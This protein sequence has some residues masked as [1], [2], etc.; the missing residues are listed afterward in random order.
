MEI[1]FQLLDC[2]YIVLDNAPIVR[3]FGKTKEGKAVCGFYR[4]FYP[5]FYVLPKQKDKVVEFLKKNFQIIKNIEEVER[6]KSINYQKEKTKMLKVTLTDPSKVPEVR[7]SLKKESFVQSVFESDILF[8]YRFMADMGIS[9]FKWLNVKGRPSKTNTV[10]CDISMDVEDFAEV[11]NPENGSFKYLSIDIETISKDVIPDSRKDEIGIISLTFNPDYNNHKSLSLVAKR[12][13]VRSNVKVFSSEKEMLQEFLRVIE[14]YDPDLLVGYNINGFDFPYILDRLR[15]NK[16]H[17][18]IGRCNQK[19]ASSRKFGQQFRNTVTGRVIVDTYALIKESIQKGNLRL[20]RLGLGDVSRALLNDEKINIPHSEIYSYWHGTEEQLSKLIDYAE[21][22]S[23]LP[24]RLLL[25]KSFID[26]FLELSKVSGLLL[27]DCLDGGEAQR[28]ENLLLREF[29]LHSF[30]LPDKPVDGTHSEETEIQTLK[31]ALVLEPTLG[32]HTES[33]VYLDFKSMYPSIFIAYN[34]CPTTLIKDENNGAD[35]IT[36]PYE[37]KFVSPKVREGVIPAILKRLIFERDKVRDSV[38]KSSGEI[39]RILEAKQLALKIMTNAFYGYTGYLRA[40]LYI[41]EIANTI[42]G[43]GR[44]LINRTKEIVEKG[45]SYQVVYGD[46]DS[47]M[48]KT[49]TRDLDEAVRIG[50]EVEKLVN[51]ELDGIVQLKIESVYKSLLILSKK[52]YA[53][54]SYEKID[55][56]WKEEIVMKGIETVRRDWC[57]ATTKTLFEVLNILLKEQ[58]TKKAFRYV[59]DITQRLERNEVPI[60]DLVITKSISKAISSYKGIQ[61]HVELVKKLKKRNGSSPGVGD[62]VGFVIVKGMQLLSE[63]AE[64]PDYVKENKIAVDSRY[65]I[66]NQILPP[67]ERVFEVIGISKN[68]LTGLGRQ[69]LLKELFRGNRIKPTNGETL[70]Q[71]LPA[72]DSFSC[73]NCDTLYKAVPL[74]GKCLQCHGELLFEFNGVKSRYLSPTRLT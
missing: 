30:I 27:Q 2:D 55:G 6:F 63:R 10:K 1:Q 23:V 25:E 61:P 43:C 56:E 31:G 7:E 49:N 46:T 28:V 13:R 38:R 58:D 53:G 22:D 33:V 3:L 67:L 45:T 70:Q 4:G 71:P 34:I 74:A 51:T 64:D 36:T 9:G 12:T 26:K 29:N 54:L 73:L 14:A 57:D 11:E 68:E 21:K 50:H 44:F 41:M 16:L 48:V 20:K 69:M 37:T 47:I 60:E 32:L 35:T 59:K 72:Y 8:K 19:P 17:Q 62:R 40:R 18:T 65:Y 5:Y 66:E 15:E 42:T 39:K 24:L 52:R